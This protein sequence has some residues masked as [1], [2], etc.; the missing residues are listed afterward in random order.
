MRQLIKPCPK[1]PFR[2]DVRPY[3]TKRRIDQLQRDCV[4]SQQE[5]HCHNTVD[6]SGDDDGRVTKNSLRC[7]G[8]TILL[9]KI[10]RPTQMMRIEER[11]GMYDRR[12]MDMESPVFNS[13]AEM[14]KAQSQ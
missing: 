6:Y 1:C 7:A 13:F 14:R 3:L 10:N 12:T 11:L 4:T 9:E 2:T 5:F 8:L